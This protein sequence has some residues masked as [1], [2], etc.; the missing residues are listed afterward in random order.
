MRGMLCLFVGVPL[1]TGSNSGDTT[2]PFEL[3]DV[4][5]LCPLLSGGMIKPKSS[6]LLSESPSASSSESPQQLSSSDSP[7]SKLHSE[8]KLSQAADICCKSY[9]L[10][11]GW[12]S[13][14]TLGLM[15][16]TLAWECVR[17]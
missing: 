7:E 11:R 14:M 9:I 5:W 13:T 12:C 3:E 1:K 10:G 17:P 16:D 6:P 15:E 2:G 8:S 4:K